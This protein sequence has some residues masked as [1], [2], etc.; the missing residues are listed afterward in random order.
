MV[1][2]VVGRIHKFPDAH[3]KDDAQTFQI[4]SGISALP[5]LALIFSCFDFRFCILAINVVAGVFP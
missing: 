3:F 4:G 5:C 1:S 2:R